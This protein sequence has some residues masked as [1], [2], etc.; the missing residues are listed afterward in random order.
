MLTW[1]GRVAIAPSSKSFIMQLFLVHEADPNAR[2]NVGQ[3]PSHYIARHGE[4]KGHYTTEGK[5]LLLK[6]GDYRCQGKR[7]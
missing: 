2:A 3:V 1:E 4:K 6:H 5:R 7:E